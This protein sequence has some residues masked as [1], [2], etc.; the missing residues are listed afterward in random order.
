MTRRFQ[1]QFVPS[2]SA[3]RRP[4]DPTSPWFRRP[5]SR[6]RAGHTKRGLAARFGTAVVAASTVMSLAACSSESAVE[7]QPVDIA[8]PKVELTNA[9]SGELASVRWKDDGAEQESTVAVTQGFAQRGGNADSDQT[10]P[11]T[12]LEIPLTSTVTSD[13]DTRVVTSEVGEPHGSND[14]LNEDI[15]TARGFISDSSTTPAGEVKGLKLGAPEKATDTAR[16]GVEMALQQ[17]HSVPIIFPTED[18]G[19]DATWT[20]ESEVEGQTTMTQKV[21]YTLLSREGDIVNLKVDVKQVP[22]VTEL[23]T[24]GDGALKVVEST[25]EMLADRVTIDLTKPLPVKGNIDFVTSVTY[26]DGSSDVRITQQT[27]RG[28][29]FK[30]GSGSKK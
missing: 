26:G 2:P 7:T 9:G 25:T 5:C 6:D 22:T 18:I 17:L 29:E 16:A 14:E 20:V 21:T 19:T 28:L 8:S 15:A 13:N 4:G 12:R 30:D 27:H 3:L 11:D 23:D 10:F 1:S 24:G